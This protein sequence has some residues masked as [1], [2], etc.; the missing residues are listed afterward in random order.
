MGA[1]YGADGYK[2]D[3]VIPEK[4]QNGK[5]DVVGVANYA[6]YPSP[7]LT[8]VVLPNSTLFI[9]TGAFQECTSLENV[10][11]GDGLE[12]IGEYA[13]NGCFVLKSI[14]LPDNVESLGKGAFQYSGLTAITLP[15]NVESLG[16]YAFQY[17]GLTAINIPDKVES[18]PMGCFLGCASLENVDFGAGLKS[19]GENAFSGCRS[20]KSVTI[21]DNV[22]TIL[23]DGF[24]FCENLEEV[25]LG[26]GLKVLGE[27]AFE[28][29]D[30]LKAITIPDKVETIE[31][32][33]VR[34]CSALE[35]VVLGNSLKTI[36]HGAFEGCPNIAEVTSKNPVPP[37]I[38]MFD[39]RPFDS[40]V[41][42]EAVLRVPIGS[43]DAYREAPEWEKFINIVETGLGG[44]GDVSNDAVGV[45]AEGGSIEIAGA[46]NAQV[47][48]YNLSG[49]LVY[50]GQSTTIGGLDR[51]I[52]IVRVAGHT[53][54]VV[55]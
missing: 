9:G 30:K 20:L 18:I 46:G 4:V 2:G 41:Y 15:D 10:D 8:S 16:Q 54:K 19:I 29:C 12:S 42:E 52:Y 13:F 5:V 28:G 22:E 40:V 55:L 44:V 25:N 39:S 17:S 33:C 47:E 6:F 49:Q 14:T 11:L 32:Y 7:E 37:A 31:R 51:S 27:F 21:P 1:L 36:E 53:F 50:S 45:T 23:H 35:K 43:G 48:V 26:A 24:G 38:E 3:I 34:D